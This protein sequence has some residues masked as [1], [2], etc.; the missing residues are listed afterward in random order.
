M[1][2]TNDTPSILRLNLARRKEILWAIA[3]R[4]IVYS[5]SALLVA[6]CFTY[7]FAFA[8]WQFFLNNAL[9]LSPEETAFLYLF[10][11][12]P[13]VFIGWILAINRVLHLRFSHFR[14]SLTSEPYRRSQLSRLLS[15]TDGSRRRKNEDDRD[16]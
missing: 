6:A 12:V 7:L 3:W 1:N 5:L 14:I 16:E 13:C 10:I 9:K 15:G 8:A 4:G 11:A 2:Q